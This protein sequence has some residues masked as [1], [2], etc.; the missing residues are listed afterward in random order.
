VF[1]HQDYLRLSG[2]VGITIMLVGNIYGFS[3]KKLVYP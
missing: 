1:T 3:L 2:L